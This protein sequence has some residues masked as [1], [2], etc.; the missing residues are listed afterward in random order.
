MKEEIIERINEINPDL[1]A[2][3]AYG[4]IIPRELADIPK[5]RVTT[6]YHYYPNIR[7]CSPIHS[8]ILN[9]DTESVSDIMHIEEE[10][11]AGDDFH[12]KRGNNGRGHAG[13]F[14]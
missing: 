4:K 12:G 3:V 9:G 2:E 5:H 11:D 13:N 8:A 14:V 7:G 1:I 10:L 6:I